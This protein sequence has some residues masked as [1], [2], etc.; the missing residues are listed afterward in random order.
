M[1]SIPDFFYDTT[2]QTVI[3]ADWLEWHK[4]PRRHA[5]PVVRVKRS[6]RDNYRTQDEDA[7]PDEWAGWDEMPEPTE[8]DII[9]NAHKMGLPV[10]RY[11]EDEMRLVRKWLES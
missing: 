9:D 5:E 7:L 1:R 8:A 10:E 3:D 2:T 11:N 6:E 4:S